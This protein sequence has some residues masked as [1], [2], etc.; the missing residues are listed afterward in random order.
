MGV[1]VRPSMKDHPGW[2]GSKKVM[3]S[4]D[5]EYC[6]D[7]ID[8]VF[9]YGKEEEGM[10]D[11]KERKELVPLGLMNSEVIKNCLKKD[12]E[13]M[14]DKKERTELVAMWLNTSKAG[15]EYLSGK[16]EDDKKV[17][18]FF[19][20]KGNDNAPDIRVMWAGDELEEWFAVWKAESKSGMEYYRG[21]IGDE[22]VVGFKNNS[23]NERAPW[24]KFYK[25]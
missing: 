23:D 18:G 2:Y 4:K 17:V 25:G 20:T 11:P 9:F 10:E 14:E 8:S 24:V 21:K 5:F 12:E 1:L 15:N 19:N 6:R 22:K 3:N 7:I 13:K 16:S